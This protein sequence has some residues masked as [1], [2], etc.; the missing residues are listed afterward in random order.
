MCPVAPILASSHRVARDWCHARTLA[1]GRH[2]GGSSH[3]DTI[4]EIVTKRAAW[5]MSASADNRT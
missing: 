3:V 4:D 5:F 2:E 1:A